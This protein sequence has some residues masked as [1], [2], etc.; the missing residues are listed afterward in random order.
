MYKSIHDLALE[1]YGLLRKWENGSTVTPSRLPSLDFEDSVT[2]AVSGG[3]YGLH[4][5]RHTGVWCPVQNL[6]LIIV[7]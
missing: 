7:P 5:R 1:G 2:A 4:C 6:V 3:V